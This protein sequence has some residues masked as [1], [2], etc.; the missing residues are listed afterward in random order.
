MLDV[1]HRCIQFARRE[2]KNWIY[3]NVV[4]CCVCACMYTCIATL[5]LCTL[6]KYYFQMAELIQNFKISKA[7][8]WPQPFDKQTGTVDAWA[9][10]SPRP[11][12]LL[13]IAFMHGYQYQVMNSFYPH[14][15]LN[16]A[17]L[18]LSQGQYPVGTKGNSQP[19]YSLSA[20]SRRRK[21]MN[22]INSWHKQS[23][24]HI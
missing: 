10:Y 21:A 19:L 7:N 24:C 22:I 23:E 6:E 4:I 17:V 14:P 12:L 2:E 13:L 5:F 20:W 15:L 8:F 3:Y 11:A 1:A 16:H 9:G 18:G